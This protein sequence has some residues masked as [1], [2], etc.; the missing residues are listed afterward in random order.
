M[1][2][3]RTAEPGRRH[4]WLAL[5]GAVVATVY[6]AGYARTEGAARAAERLVA[7]SQA[8]ASAAG[9]ASAGSQGSRTSGAGASPT[10]AAFRDGSYT[11]TGWGPHGPVQVKVV[12]RSG[13]IVSA[14]I[15]QCG[16]T[17]PCSVIANLPAAVV[18]TQGQQADYVS[19][20]TASSMA[21]QQAVASALQQ[22]RA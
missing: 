4:R 1:A 19:G 7:G 14:N 22:A 8:G 16:T 5:S 2:A 15:L 18:A 13:R 11:A 3:A 21:Y 20:A 9:T 12:V 10:Q 6:L 17:Y